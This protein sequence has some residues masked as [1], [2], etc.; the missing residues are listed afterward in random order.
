LLSSVKMSSYLKDLMRKKDKIEQDIK[1]WYEV[2]ESQANVGM[3]EPLVDSQGFPRNDIDL[4]QVRTA[5]HNI[6]CLQNDHREVMKQ[7]EQGLEEYHSQV[8]NHD[9]I[10][11]PMMSQTQNKPDLE[12]FATIDLI[13]RSSPAEKSGLKIGDLLLQFGSVTKRNFTGMKDIANVVQHS[14]DKA[15]H[16][17]VKRENRTMNISIVPKQ[18]EGRGL[19]GCNIV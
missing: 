10:E 4:V 16:L 8:A 6:N 3:N 13:S 12:E 19:L 17:M 2:L 5:R 18:W 1:T 15:V 11:T 9:V 7:I 14:V